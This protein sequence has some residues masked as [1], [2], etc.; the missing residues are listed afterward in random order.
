ML[1]VPVLVL[2]AAVSSG[3]AAASWLGSVITTCMPATA[4]LVGSTR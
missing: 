3:A 1:A 2:A 4:P